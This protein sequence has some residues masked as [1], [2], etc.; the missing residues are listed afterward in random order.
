MNQEIVT[1][2]L[3]AAT[4]G[5]TL[6]KS[7]HLVNAVHCSL[8]SGNHTP[9]LSINIFMV[10]WIQQFTIPFVTRATFTLL[11]TIGARTECSPFGFFNVF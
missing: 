2:V 6:T 1:N 9:S 8:L 3:V 7:E 11:A 4:S 10:S 5:V